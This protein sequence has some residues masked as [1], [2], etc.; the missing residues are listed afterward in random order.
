LIQSKLK[1]KAIKLDI[2]KLRD[3]PASAKLF[4]KILQH[5][6]NMTQKDLINTS[7][8][9]E[10]TVRYALNILLKKGIITPQPHFT[11]ARQSVYGV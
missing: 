10:R 11:D 5:E 4:Y 2:S 6:G 3:L 8:L 9:P 1:K 7:L